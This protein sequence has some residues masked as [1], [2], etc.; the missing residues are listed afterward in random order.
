MFLKMKNINIFNLKIKKLA[1]SLKSNIR[2]NVG[3]SK[4]YIL[5][6]SE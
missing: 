2:L 4:S 3:I 1:K 5:K 6:K